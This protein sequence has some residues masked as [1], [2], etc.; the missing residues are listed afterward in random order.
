MLPFSSIASTQIRFLLDNFNDSNYES[1]FHQLSQISL[2]HIKFCDGEEDTTKSSSQLKPQLLASIFRCQLD[3]PNFSTVLCEALSINT[4][5]YHELKFSVSEKIAFGLGFADSEELDVRS[6]GQSFCMS[7]IEELCANPCSIDSNEQIHNVVSFLSRSKGAAKL[8]DSFIQMLTLLDIKNRALL[9]PLSNLIDMCQVSSIRESDFEHDLDDI[10][11]EIEK[12]MSMADIVKELG[13][14][15]TVDASHCKDIL[16]IFLPLTEVAICR[17]LSTIAPTHVGLED[18]Q[19]TYSTFCSAGKICC[20]ADSSSLSSWNSDV[21]LKSIELL[22][23]DTNWVHVMENLDHEGFY[24]PSEDSFC[25]FMSV[26][27]KFVPSSCHMRVVWNNAEGQISFLRYAVSASPE[28]FTFVHSAR[29]L[30]YV[31]ADHGLVMSCLLDVLCQLAEM[32]YAGSARSTLGY[33]LKHCHEVLLL[34]VSQ[35]NTAYNLLQC[36]VLSSV[37]PTVLGN[38]SRAGLILHLWNVNHNVVLRG[39]LDVQNFDSDSMMKFFCICQEFK[40]LSPVLDMAPF[41]FSIKLAALAFG[42]EQ[43][44]LKK[45][46]SENLSTYGD[47]LFEVCLMFLK[48]LR[49]DVPQDFPADEHSTAVAN[50]YLETVPIFIKVLLGH[51]GQNVSHRHLLEEIKN[52]HIKWKTDSYFL[53][54][55]SGKVCE[56]SLV[57]QLTRYKDSPEKREQSICDCIISKF[58]EEY[59]YFPKY[60]ER[61]LRIAAIVFGSLIKHQLVTHRTFDIALS[62]VLDALRE[63]AESNMFIFGAKALEQF[64]DRSI[65]WPQYCNDILQISHLRESHLE[66]VAS[67][68]NSLATISSR[69]SPSN[70]SSIVP[71]NQHKEPNPVPLENTEA[72]VVNS[73]AIVPYQ[74]APSGPAT[75]SSSLGFLH[76]SR[77]IICARILRQHPYHT[78]FGSLLSTET[79]VAA[80][81]DGILPRRRLELN[82]QFGAL[83]CGIYLTITSTTCLVLSWGFSLW[84]FET[85]CIQ[86]EHADILRLGD[87]RTPYGAF[88]TFGIRMLL[89]VGASSSAYCLLY[90]CGLESLATS[91]P[92]ILYFSCPLYD[93]YYFFPSRH[94]VWRRVCSLCRIFEAP[95]FVDNFFF[96]VFTSLSKDYA[97]LTGATCSILGVWGLHIN[98]LCGP[99]SV[100][101]LIFSLFPF[102]IL[103]LL[104][105]RV[106]CIRPV[107]PRGQVAVALCWNGLMIGYPIKDLLWTLRYSMETDNG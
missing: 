62:G 79:H 42:K 49:F 100:L 38:F 106:Y 43:I 5:I 36:E 10:L 67:I 69:H 7:Q 60:P 81:E 20:S 59:K 17:L 4:R 40:I 29:Q 89:A 14:G 87:H 77:G 9:S 65:E 23:P 98:W 102:F 90:A 74:N 57:Q 11:A 86:Y 3:K 78:G 93:I 22:A 101:A 35:T 94:F 55:F 68:E 2:D 21:L 103:I 92:V 12:E 97:D 41:S 95:D 30:V 66:L 64:V 72:I 31:E 70:G 46:L 1:V 56:F 32:G 44:H 13:Y 45:W 52:S 75:V 25:F 50:A 33:P 16:S 85:C 24:L 58:F 83:K 99:H 18:L 91:M 53:Q 34:G 28:I 61:K 26:Y 82:I 37:F 105:L 107:S 8:V 6:I 27:A 88:N 63:F 96:D 73:L 51:A 84:I 104:S 47:I 15:F 71:T 39:L 19:S 48:E 76:P 54:M 80:V